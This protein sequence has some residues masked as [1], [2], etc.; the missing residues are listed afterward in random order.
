MKKLTAL[1]L[2]GIM[3][4]ALCAC[5]GRGEKA[6]GEVSYD[7]PEG[8]AIPDDAVINVT[9]T[10]QASWPYRE[11]WA[12]WECIRE[13]IGGTVNVN[14]VPA[15]DFGTKFPLIMAS[16]ES[17][18]DVIGF[19]GKPSGFASYCEQ[20]AFLA[21]DDYP[22]YMKDYNAF[23]DSLPENEQLMRDV[24]RA[25]DGKVYYA[26]IYGTERS[27][28]VRT[29]LYREDIFKKHNL[30]APKTMDDLYNVSKKLKELY[31]ASYPF[32]MRQG[33]TNINVIGSSWKPNFHWGTYYDFEN[34]KWCYGAT[35]DVMY[36]MV[37]YLNKMVSEKLMPADFYTINAATWQEL[38]STDRGFIMPEYNVRIDFFNSIAHAAGNDEFNLTAV[39]PPYV[40]NGMGVPMTTK[41][42][43]DPMG[44]SIC[45]TGDA[46][47]IANAM[48]YVNWF[49][50]DEGSA[51][52]SWGKE[53]ET[54]Q[55]VDG[56][57]KFIAE[58]DADLNSLYGIGTVGT[59]LRVDPGS[60]VEGFSDEAKEVNDF[61]LG[62]IYPNLDPTLYLEFSADESQLIADYETSLK[63]L[64]E[65]N[66]QKFIIGQRPLTEWDKF[67]EELA[68]M[69]VD[70]LLSIYENAYNKIK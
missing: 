17:F 39:T 18:P 45:N 1:I 63:T 61:I 68:E 51:A 43:Y 31:P 70:E 57:K 60:V 26:P 58:E 54:Y 62:N 35:E 41:Y 37:V 69:P 21:L 16:P 40:E 23:W 38:V 9:I 46:G 5:T 66:L 55:V 36:D 47:R 24:R 65:E 13:G 15:T 34:E 52:I 32:C 12:V 33:K 20:G 53:G 27:T 50:S 19:Q 28:N 2:V 14:A 42:N 29:W 6:G 7:I 25:A 48:R 3:L 8:K 59:Y 67:Q 64:V 11:D 49:Y 10:S 44:Y 4:F 30:E 56:K 22:E